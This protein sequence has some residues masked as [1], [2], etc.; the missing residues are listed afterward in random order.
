MPP[1]ANGH[2]NGSPPASPAPVPP[3]PP[4]VAAHKPPTFDRATLRRFLSFIVDPA[5]GC[6]ELRIFSAGHERNFIVRDTRYSKT[7]GG[8]YDDVNALAIDLQRLRDV[9]GYVTANPVH[10]DFLSKIDNRIERHTKATAAHNILCL[11][12]LY[13][14]VDSN[15]VDARSPSDDISATDAE[16]AAAVARRDLI[17]ADHPDLAASAIWGKSGA[18]SWSGCPIIPTTTPTTATAW[19]AGRWRPCRPGTAT[20]PPTWT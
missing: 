18:G 2:A 20:P 4:A 11:R 16:L 8:W 9:S 15:V 7:L 13:I 3:D 19:S 17:L 6:T 12:W 14:D 5:V 10:R 1:D